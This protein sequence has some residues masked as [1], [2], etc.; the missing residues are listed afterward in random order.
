MATAT[1]ASSTASKPTRK[2]K[3]VRLYTA[4]LAMILYLR[5]R[6][7][8][9][10]VGLSGSVGSHKSFQSVLPCGNKLL[11]QKWDKT[12]YDEHRRLVRVNV[13]VYMCM[14]H[15]IILYR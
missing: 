10:T 14:T 9:H 3:L 4:V 11:Q 5:A 6:C 2:G 15:F 8:Y 12:Y 1:K 7:F 13:C